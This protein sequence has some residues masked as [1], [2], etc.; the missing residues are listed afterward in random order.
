MIS[1]DGVVSFWLKQVHQKTASGQDTCVIPMSLGPKIPTSTR[2]RPQS[3][4]RSD[5]FFWW[6]GLFGPK[7]WSRFFW[8]I[9][10]GHGL[11]KL[12]ISGIHP[13]LGE[14]RSGEALGKTRWKHW[15]FNRDPHNG[16]LQSSILL[17][18]TGIIPYKLW[19]TRVLDT[20]QIKT[21]KILKISS[22]VTQWKE[23][24]FFNNYTP[25][26]E[27]LEPTK[28]PMK[29]E[30]HLNHPPSFLGFK[31]LIFRGVNHPKNCGSWR[32]WGWLNGFHTT[33]PLQLNKKH[34]LL[35]MSSTYATFKQIIPKWRFVM[36]ISWFLGQTMAG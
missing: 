14:F 10:K 22:I 34:L 13:E 15:L 6:P 5:P 16:L 36:L 27:E 24:N 23:G 12:D 1:L 2:A 30:N 20:A 8:G 18:S 3:D 17:G 28:H 33:R 9:P 26:N 19:T 21:E 32:S 29:Q 35:F 4:D 25:E 31:M 7:K 11:K